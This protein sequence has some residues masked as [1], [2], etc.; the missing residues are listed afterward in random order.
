MTKLII[1]ESPTKAREVS[2]FLGS[3]Y[4]VIASMGHV[5]DLPTNRMG[6]NPP[7]FIPEYEPTERGK[8]TLAQIRKL[9]AEA[10]I[11][12]LASDP[13]REGEAISWHIAEALRLPSR[14]TKRIT[15]T[16]V[17]KTAVLRALENPRKVD[18]NLVAAQEAR[19]VADRIIGYGVSPALCKA[20][21]ARLSAGRTQT[22][23]LGILVER[24]A[25]I[26]AHNTTHHFGATLIL[27]NGVEA[28]WNRKPWLNGGDYILDEALAKAAASVKR[29]VVSGVRRQQKRTM[30]PAPFTTSAFQ[31]ACSSQL[32]IAPEAA[33]RIAQNL[34]ETGR[35]TYMRTDSTNLSEEA[36]QDIRRYAKTRGLPLPA[37]PN[38]FHTRARNAQEAHE[39][40]RPTSMEDEGKNLNGDAAR[41]YR[42]IHAR[43][44]A[45]QLS[46][47][48]EDVTQATFTATAQEKGRDFEYTATGAK[49]LEKGFTVVTG[50]PERTTLP[51]MREGESLE[52]ESGTVDALKTQPRP[53]FNEASFL[54][55]LEARGIG[56][57]ST[58]ASILSTLY[59]RNYIEKSGKVLRPTSL[60]TAVYRALS[61]ARFSQV[62]Y[63]A[64]MEER[65][66]DIAEGKA[67]YR[68][69]VQEVFSESQR[70]ATGVKPFSVPDVPGR[71][72]SA[73]KTRGAANSKPVRRT[74][75]RKPRTTTS[76]SAS[77]K[78][79]K[80]RTR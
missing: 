28:T 79:R 63:T 39:A 66:D 61:H 67:G 45:C 24:E 38:Q 31:Q 18:T 43:A 22:P 11:I 76:S 19:R 3:G 57:P 78:T 21:N 16:E 13:D 75:T 4:K 27:E 1:V 9:A 69:F 53:R 2:H 56:R 58:F 74:G 10:E 8:S 26:R 12:Y 33:M 41:V 23:A 52:V 59:F 50:L 20:G 71:E 62:P 47:L 17:T 64:K 32:G 68:D 35:I 46:A 44:L 36:I 60:G 80:A 77:G 25:E 40:I 42:L 34:F 7:D 49:V 48:V 5:R 70:D 37:E 72:S 65:L 55:E 14:K 6:V 15:Y 30:P 51:I 73:S 54:A 29:V